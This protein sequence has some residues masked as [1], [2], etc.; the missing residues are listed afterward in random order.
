[1]GQQFGSI[2]ELVVTFRDCL[3]AIAPIV[4]KVGIEWREFKQYDEW[5]GIASALY[6]SVVASAVAYTVEGESFAKIAPYDML[7]RDFGQASYLFSPKFGQDAV[8]IRLET[9]NAPFDTAV[10]CRLNSDGTPS[11][12]RKRSL[13]RQTD[14]RALLRS[15]DQEREIESVIFQED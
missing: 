14:F 10:F 4:E 8:F 6:S 11:A 7:L 1:M 5:D 2:T 12:E 13:L 3:V 9:S 15:K